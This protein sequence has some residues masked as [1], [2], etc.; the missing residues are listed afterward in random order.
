MNN[1][2]EQIENCPSLEA[3]SDFADQPLDPKIQA[4]LGHCERCRRLVEDFMQ[5]DNLVGEIAQPSPDL[6]D[7]IIEACRQETTDSPLPLFEAPRTDNR[8]LLGLALAVAAAFV[9]VLAVTVVQLT[10]IQPE[11]AVA[12]AH[13]EAAP[14]HATATELDEIAP[15]PAQQEDARPRESRMLPQALL[16]LD[17]S[18]PATETTY[19]FSDLANL[20][21][22]LEKSRL[23]SVSPTS[24]RMRTLN[25]ET[26]RHPVDRV[27][28]H[29]WSVPDLEESVK[30]INRIAQQCRSEIVWQSMDEGRIRTAR[31]VASDTELQEIVDCLYDSQWV[32]LSPQ[33]PQPHN[34]KAVAFDDSDILYTVK[35]LAK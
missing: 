11:V 17:G 10:R 1:N 23:R 4:H 8:R 32:L 34:D 6:G 27:T 30:V 31:F 29:I 9:I 33:L 14:R 26:A 20:Q 13:A 7:R 25:L 15:A 22:Q 12:V 2:V 3:L 16:A 21:G 35:L 5:I 19:D 28:E 24:G 18:A